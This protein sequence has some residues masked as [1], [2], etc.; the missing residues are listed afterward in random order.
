MSN[1]TN[2]GLTRSGKGC[3]IVVL[4]MATVGVK[5]SKTQN[6]ESNKL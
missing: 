6:L 2:D 4:I 3:S 5:G 1:I